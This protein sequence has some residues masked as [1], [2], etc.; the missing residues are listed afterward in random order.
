MKK[1]EIKKLSEREHCLT[2]SS[3]Y[4]GS[5]RR[6]THTDYVYESQYNKTNIR[7]YKRFSQDY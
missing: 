5:I 4:L 3:M 2:R 6:E 1:N 7:I